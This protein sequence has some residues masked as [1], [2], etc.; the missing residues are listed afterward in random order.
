MPRSAP[1]DPE[2]FAVTARAKASRTCVTCA[3][4]RRS[5]SAAR[6]YERAKAAC[7]KAGTKPPLKRYYEVLVASFG[8]EPTFTAL[9][10][11]EAHGARG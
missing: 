7:K 4:M 8:F 5:P 6:W 11:H 9:R 10:N 2:V 1:P 3:F